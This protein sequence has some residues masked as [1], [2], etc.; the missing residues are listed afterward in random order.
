[1]PNKMDEWEIRVA[2][3]LSA[4]HSGVEEVDQEFKDRTGYIVS[5]RTA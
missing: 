4:H 2:L 1:M 3:H 5:L